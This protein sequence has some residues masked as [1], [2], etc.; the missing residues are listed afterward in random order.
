VDRLFIQLFADIEHLYIFLPK[1]LKAKKMII[2]HFLSVR[3]L[4]MYERDVERDGEGRSYFSWVASNVSMFRFIFA[5]ISLD[6]PKF[7][8]R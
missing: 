1:P 8:I 6:V 7:V 2:D 3:R 4:A 5:S